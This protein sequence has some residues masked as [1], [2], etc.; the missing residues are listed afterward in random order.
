MINLFVIERKRG[1]LYVYIEK[2]EDIHSIVESCGTSF[3]GRAFS[4]SSYLRL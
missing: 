4:G 2:E 1:K 3:C